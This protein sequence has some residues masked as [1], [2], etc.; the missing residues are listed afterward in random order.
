VSGLQWRRVRRLAQII[1]TA[2]FFLLAALTYRGAAL[3]LPA[4]FFFRLDPLLA[5]AAS[6]AARTRLTTFLLSLVLLALGF[7]FGRVWCG[8]LC[9]LGAL[10]DW[11]SPRAP[12]K[13]ETHPSWRRVKY[14]LLVVI[15]A[16]ALLGNLTFLIF[17]PLT[18]LNRTFA[19]AFLPALNGLLVA[20]EAALYPLAPMQPVIDALEN[21]WRGTVL[22][23]QQTYYD[24]GAL[25]AMVLA[26]IIALNWI[27]PRFWCRYLCPLGAVYALTARVAWVKPHAVTDC[28]HC[29]VCM[30][31]CPTS[32]IGVKKDG[33]HVDAAECVMCMDCVAACPQSVVQF[34]RGASAVAE[35]APALTRREALGSLALGVTAVALFSSAPAARREYAFAIRPPGAQGA[36]FLSKCIRCGECVRVC[37]TGGLQAASAET[38][39][40]RLWTPNLVPR[41]GYCDF[42]CNACGQMCPTGAIP[43]LSLAQKRDQV[44]GTAYIDTN[45]CLPYATNTPCIVCEEM[46]PL[47]PKAI[48]L[49]QVEVL[50]SD[51]Q[52]V[53]LQRP[54]VDHARCIGCGICE[55]QCPQTGPAAIRVYTPTQIP[56]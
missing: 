23:A 50:K 14:A 49:A 37:P 4:D 27:A 2:L 6:L 16:A 11:F 35:S 48:S 53:M 31:L 1:A 8:W 47:S 34:R 19:A 30:H 41:L 52:T 15:L 44:I 56:G 26:G 10:L 40:A 32:A 9:P 38:G 12:R 43:L 54:L 29:A 28:N 5:F 13:I 20:V 46:C 24:A 39:L 21:N 45:R 51:G 17:D 55:Y 22:P 25:F 18:L 36:D 33:L 42:S 3:A 7:V